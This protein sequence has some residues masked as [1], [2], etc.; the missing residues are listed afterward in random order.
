MNTFL[1][2]LLIAALVLVAIKFSPIFLVALIA[3]LIVA[4]VLG[5]LGVSL[6][7]LLAAILLGLAVALSPIW[8]TVLLVMGIVSLF[9]KSNSTPPPVA[10][11]PMATAA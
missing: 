8:V 11:P 6:L 3:G 2:I 1:K 9:K 5:A 4:A 10:P 7:V